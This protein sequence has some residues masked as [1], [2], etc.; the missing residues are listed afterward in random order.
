MVHHTWPCM[1]PSRCIVTRLCV[2][3]SCGNF[4]SNV[5]FLIYNW[6]C[7]IFFKKINEATVGVPYLVFF[8]YNSSWNTFKAL[9]KLI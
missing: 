7:T 1:S 2:V 3:V 6:T 4:T 5:V 9:L 8:P